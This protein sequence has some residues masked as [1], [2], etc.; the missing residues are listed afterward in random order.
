MVIVED[1]EDVALAERAMLAP[2]VDDIVVVVD[3]FGRAFTP[4]FWAGV[5]VAV[6]DL[7]LPGFHGEDICRYLAAE[8]PS[9][10]RVIC[11]AKPTYELPDLAALAHVV[12]RKPF[13]LEDL[14]HAVCGP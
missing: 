8:F 12:L 1:M 14:V 4:D 13:A 7:M 3:D 9:V 2:V 5:D 10:R 11:T 6:V